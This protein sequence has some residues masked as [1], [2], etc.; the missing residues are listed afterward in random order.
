MTE[1]SGTTR[2]FL[3]AMLLGFGLILERVIPL[4]QSTQPKYTRV[5]RNLLIAALSAVVLKFTFFPLLI[6][7]VQFSSEHKFGLLNLV[8]LGWPTR[9]AISLVLLDYTHYF[10]HQMN[11]KF[12]ILWRFH[13]VHHIDLDLDV[14]TASRFHFGELLASTI[15]R[16]L[17]IFIFGIDLPTL[18]LFE[19]AVT[20]F[21]QFHHSNV[22][23]P[24]RLERILNLIFVTPRMHGIHHSIVRDETD[25]NYG[26]IFSIWDR[27]HRTL[28]L[29]VSQNKI[30]IGVP[31][32]PSFLEQTLFRSLFFP[33]I[34]QRKWQSPDGKIPT[35]KKSLSD[36]LLP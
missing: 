32:Y 4:R 27:I 6:W 26:T 24:I 20:A 2:I 16:I 34:L 25:S 36:N 29:G 22:N 8:E 15:F 17:E 7:S 12:P 33:F 14:S 21:A 30:T 9:L 13:N 10:W 28:R 23:L 3:L 31:S 1:I 11:H 5:F 35:R 19:T 18:I